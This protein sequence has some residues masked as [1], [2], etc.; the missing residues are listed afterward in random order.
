MGF[1][2]ILKEVYGKLT[3]RNFV[4]FKVVYLWNFWKKNGFN[5][6]NGLRICLEGY[7]EVGLCNSDGG[8]SYEVL[9]LGL[10]IF[11]FLR[12]LEG[13]EERENGIGVWERGGLG[14]NWLI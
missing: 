4:Y 8:R 14:E 13:K 9:V 6:E 1:Y 3:L 12:F 7:S 2:I 10:F 5:L 11:G